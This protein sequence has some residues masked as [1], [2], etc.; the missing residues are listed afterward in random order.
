[1]AKITREKEVIQITV[2]FKAKLREIENNIPNE[3]EVEEFVV[4]EKFLNDAV[5]PLYHLIFQ[6]NLLEL[7]E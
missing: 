7:Q 1:M 2:Q 5:S 4:F 3:R 6:R